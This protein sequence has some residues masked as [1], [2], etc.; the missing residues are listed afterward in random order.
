M[1]RREA[2]TNDPLRLRFAGLGPLW[3]TCWL[4]VWPLAMHAIFEEH[5]QPMGTL[6]PRSIKYGVTLLAV[7]LVGGITP[8]L[9]SGLNLRRA[10]LWVLLVL[11][12]LWWGVSPGLLA[13]GRR[14]SY[15]KNREHIAALKEHGLEAAWIRQHWAV[16]CR[17]SE[18]DN[19]DLAQ[20]VP[21][22]KA[23]PTEG[24]DLGESAVTAEGIKM[25]SQVQSIRTFWLPQHVNRDAEEL[26]SALPFVELWLMDVNG[27]QKALRGPQGAAKP[28]GED[29]M[30]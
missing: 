8:L 15:A 25:L 20:C 10:L 18:F 5:G 13:E 1:C 9:W 29:Q 27:T 14:L 23:L 16:I 19:E 24:L 3:Y 11:W 12:V 6:A 22:L 30:G 17:D 2:G 4:V 7:L 26:R 28:T 21:H